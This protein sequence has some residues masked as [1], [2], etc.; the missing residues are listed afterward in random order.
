MLGLVSIWLPQLLSLE[1]DRMTEVVVVESA[2]FFSGALLGCL[3]PRKVWRWALAAF[4]AFAIRDAMRLFADPKNAGTA[5]YM[6]ALN[7]V[8]DNTP[9]YLVWCL[10]V[11]AGSYI[12]YFISSAGLR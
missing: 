1:A 3:R 8:A 2:L 12:G 9:M 6:L 7:H 11:L 10:P 4:L 5:V